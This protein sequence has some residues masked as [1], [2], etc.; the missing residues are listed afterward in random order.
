MISKYSVVVVGTR[1]IIL[2]FMS[3]T[4]SVPLTSESVTSGQAGGVFRQLFYSAVLGYYL[5]LCLVVEVESRDRC[6]CVISLW[7]M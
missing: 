1:R 2:I 5:L 7:Y 6:L 4:F 3:K